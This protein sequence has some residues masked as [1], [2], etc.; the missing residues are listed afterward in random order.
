MGPRF[1][2]QVAVL[3]MVYFS[4]IILCD[5]LLINECLGLVPTRFSSLPNTTFV[6]FIKEIIKFHLILCKLTLNLE[7]R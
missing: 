4:K 5:P 6:D 3:L 2:T 1:L 7:C